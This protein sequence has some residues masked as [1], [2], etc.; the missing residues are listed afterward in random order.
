MF[1]IR[2]LSNTGIILIIIAMLSGAA[3][4]RALVAITPAAPAQKNIAVPLS[5]PTDSNMIFNMLPGGVNVKVGDTFQ[6]TISVIN[7]TNMFGWQIYVTYDPTKLECLKAS[8][9]DNYILSS[10]VT[11]CNSLATYNGTELP[12]GEPLQR[13]SN[14]VGWVL[15]GDCQLGANQQT[16]SGSGNLCQIEFKAIEPGTSSLALINDF[17]NG[18]QA[19]VVHPDISSTI[20]RIAPAASYSTVYITPQK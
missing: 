4:V 8:F 12:S 18:F 16:I 17:N 20:S 1:N 11:V 13:I 19:F 3:T 7:A 9:P 5:Y 6:V 10:S 15:A 14:S 2:D